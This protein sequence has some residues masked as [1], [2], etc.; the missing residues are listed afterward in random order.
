MLGEGRATH[1]VVSVR[2]SVLA[3]KRHPLSLNGLVWRG[4][5][6]PVHRHLTRS[7]SR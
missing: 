5:Q 7:T 2:P 6:R 3:Y 1:A 4:R